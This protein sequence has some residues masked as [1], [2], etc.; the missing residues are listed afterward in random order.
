MTLKQFICHPNG[1]VKRGALSRV[2][3]HLSVWPAT[4]KKWMRGEWRPSPEKSEQIR[5]MIATG[6]S[7]DADYSKCGRPKGPSR[8][9]RPALVKG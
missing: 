1:R 3:E 5:E 4:V 9:K 6:I 8:K 2:S 7:L